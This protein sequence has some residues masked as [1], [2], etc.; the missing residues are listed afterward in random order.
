MCNQIFK[1]WLAII[2][3]TQVHKKCLKWNLKLN[4]GT[5]IS[6][7]QKT[8]DSTFT[9]ILQQFKNS[10]HIQLSH[11]KCWTHAW[12]NTQSWPYFPTKTHFSS[13]KLKKIFL[14]IEKGPS[15]MVWSFRLSEFYLN[16]TLSPC[17]H[18]FFE[19][20]QIIKLDMTNEYLNFLYVSH[21]F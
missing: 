4:K 16:I 13:L 14:G 2:N 21:F 9:Q 15:V 12:L 5:Q 10:D 11:S 1:L 3:G 19:I 17:L 20:H 8:Y 18:I 6:L 7:Q